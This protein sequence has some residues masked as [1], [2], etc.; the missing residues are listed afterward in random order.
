MA[1][2]LFRWFVLVA[3]NHFL[4]HA[5]MNHFNQQFLISVIWL[6]I[7]V[8]ILAIQLWL[9]LLQTN[10]LRAG[11][12]LFL[13]PVFG[14]IIASLVLSD[15]MNVYTI[16]GIILVLTALGIHQRKASNQRNE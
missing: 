10:T 7:P 11:L 15:Q 5:P 9:W 3:L 13:C 16:T 1:G 2:R 4:Y 6:A 8:S 12:W 14:F